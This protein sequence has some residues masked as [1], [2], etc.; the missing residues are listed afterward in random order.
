MATD[1]P[2]STFYTRGGDHGRTSLADGTRVE[3]DDPR[4]EACGDIDELNSHIGLLL[5]AI[6]PD[7]HPKALLDAQ[8]R[9]FAIGALTSGIAAPSYLPQEAEVRA[10]ETEISA[11]ERSGAERFQGFVLPCGSEAAARAHV[12]RAVCRRVERHLVTA[13]RISPCAN[14]TPVCAYLNRLSA[15]LFVFARHLNRLSAT[16]EILL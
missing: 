8:R 5:A 9:L 15:Y 1:K 14:T 3:K 6:H 12:C 11:L 10:L 2:I 16:P 7:E 13:F 4:I